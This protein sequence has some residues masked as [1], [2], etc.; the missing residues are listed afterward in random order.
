VVPLIPSPHITKPRIPMPKPGELVEQPLF[1]VYRRSC[2]RAI[3]ACL[4]AADYRMF[5]FFA[6]VRT[7]YVTPDELRVYDPELR[8]F[9]N[10]NTPDD[11]RDA[12]RLAMGS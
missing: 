11:W 12:Q 8:S 9:F 1:A 2:L 4:D 5:S 3:A 6:N 7:R 10:V